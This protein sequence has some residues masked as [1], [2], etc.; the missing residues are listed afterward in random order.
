MEGGGRVHDTTRVERGKGQRRELDVT[1]DVRAWTKRTS[2][3]WNT[4]RAIL[5]KWQKLRMRQPTDEGEFTV[6]PDNVAVD[7]KPVASL[8]KVYVKQADG[9]VRVFD[10]GTKVRVRVVKDADHV[11]KRKWYVTSI[12]PLQ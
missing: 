9:T 6:K 8:G 10:A 11:G 4:V 12:F 2:R 5:V 7:G 3:R 1:C